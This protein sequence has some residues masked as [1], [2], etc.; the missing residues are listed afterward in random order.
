[1]LTWDVM[2][3]FPGECGEKIALRVAEHLLEDYR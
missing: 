2:E 1:M 3:P